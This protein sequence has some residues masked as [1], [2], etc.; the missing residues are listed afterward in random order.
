MPVHG[1]RSARKSVE[2]CDGYVVRIT[3]EL[4]E[5]GV[6]LVRNASCTLHEAMSS[7]RQTGPSASEDSSEDQTG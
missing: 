3:S 5:V 7:A 4:D 2:E 1:A 6:A